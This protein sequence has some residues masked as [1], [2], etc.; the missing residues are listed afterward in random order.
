MFKEKVGPGEGTACAQAE[1]F[2]KA[3]LIWGTEALSQGWGE[4]CWAH[5]DGR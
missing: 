2:E 1:R 5:S 3:W 4:G